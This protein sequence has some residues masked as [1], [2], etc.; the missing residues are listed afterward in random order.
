[1]LQ[2]ACNVQNLLRLPSFAGEA[3]GLTG[4][5]LRLALARQQKYGPFSLILLQS[6]R[7]ET[8]VPATPRSPARQKTYQ[9][10][11][12][13]CW[14]PSAHLSERLLATV[15]E[16]WAARLPSAS[17]SHSYRTGPLPGPAV[18]CS[19]ALL[20]VQVGIKPA[21]IQRQC[22]KTPT[23]GKCYPHCFHMRGTSWE[24]PLMHQG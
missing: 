7:W 3:F 22:N 6:T 11:P 8:R 12:F 9:G 20:H 16:G 19:T 15:S 5:D 17:R 1:M 14:I 2:H 23:S 18:M 10:G 24:H 4:Y 13:K 21:H